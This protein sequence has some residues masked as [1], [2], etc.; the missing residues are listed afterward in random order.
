MEVM[1]LSGYVAE[2]KVA[3]AEK[4]LAPA[5]RTGAGLDKYD[6]DLTTGAI[7]ALI[8]QYCRESGVRNLKKH[9]DKV[10]RKA[11]L[12]IV[13]DEAGT[14]DKNKKETSTEEDKPAASVESKP[15]EIEPA[16]ASTV[17]ASEDAKSTRSIVITK[18][19]LKDYVGSPVFTSDRMYETTPPGVVMGL[20]WTSMGGTVLYIES[21]L[22]SAITEG[23]GKGSFHRTGQMGDVMKES[24]TIAY[25]YARAFLARRF[26]SNKFFEK[27][28]VHMHV[29]EGATPKDGP[30][31][32]T[33]MATSLLSLALGEAAAPDVAMT[34]ELTLTG[35][36]LRIG[37]VREKAIA[38]KRSGV[39]RIILPDANRADWD[40]LPAY[41]REGLQPTFVKWYDDIFEV[42]FPQVADEPG[43]AEA[44]AAAVAAADARV[45]SKVHAPGPMA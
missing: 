11:A 22:E 7:E 20:A 32:G 4:Y 44:A 2:E 29:P 30:S 12:Q 21:V 25:T 43:A 35:K 26:P 18:D 42:V 6:I 39:A 36:V 38:A 27:A 16:A 37:G 9:I 45:E 31:A 15:N 23:G 3:I 28:S 41:V 10:Y 34:G 13:Q 24:S 5:A 40:E 33:T 17:A 14:K 19:N 8:K 1:T